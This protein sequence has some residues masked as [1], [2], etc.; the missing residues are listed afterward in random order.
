MEGSRTLGGGEEWWV[1]EEK[2]RE[3]EERVQHEELVG[4]DNRKQTVVH[5]KRG[6][7]QKTKL[8]DV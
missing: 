5:T 3:E 2:N 7:R 8:W 1:K 4:W 6:A